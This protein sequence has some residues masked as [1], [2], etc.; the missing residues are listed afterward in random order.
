MTANRSILQCNVD[1]DNLYSDSKKEFGGTPIRVACYYPLHFASEHSRARIKFS[2]WVRSFYYLGVTLDAPS[3]TWNIHVDEICR[4][5]NLRLNIMRALSGSNWGADRELMLNVY[6]TYIRPKLLYGIS[7]VASTSTTSLERLERIQIAALRIALGARNTSPIKALQAESNIPPLEEHI[8]SICC[9]TF[10]RMRAQ[11]HPI[12]QNMREDE[13]VEDRVWTKHFKTPFI[14]RC[15]Q[16]MTAW[17]IEP[18]TDAKVVLLP[19]KPPWEIT[20]LQ[21]KWDLESDVRKDQSAEEVKAIA[22]QTIETRYIA[23]NF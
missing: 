1:I 5:A 9:N 16:I 2:A 6:V 13:S 10:F 15:E 22:T 19:S 14:I 4:E 3:L 18:E 20:S 17:N 12:L 21:L 8:K 23:Q 11:D 7:A